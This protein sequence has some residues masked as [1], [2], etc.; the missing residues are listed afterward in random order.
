[1][2]VTVVGINHKTAPIEVRKKF[3]LT[4]IQQD[5]LLSELR[6]HPEITEA[7]VLSTCNR[8]EVYC[9]SLKEIKTAFIIK[10]LADVRS[11]PSARELS[12]YFYRHE[13]T[14]A[15]RHLFQVVCGLDSLVLGEKQIMGQVKSALE[16]AR[17][18][19]MFQRPFNI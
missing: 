1:M 19:G 10:L 5:L 17:V 4:Q 13:G 6:S 8:T 3:F 15:Y 16:R 2:T 12:R 11:L 7:F 9:H 14:A 18:K